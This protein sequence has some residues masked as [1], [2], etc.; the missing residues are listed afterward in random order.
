[1]R[2]EIVEKTATVLQLTSNK[3]DW[4]THYEKYQHVLKELKIQENVDKD[5]VCRYIH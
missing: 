5:A 1:M 3:L 2:N 4:A